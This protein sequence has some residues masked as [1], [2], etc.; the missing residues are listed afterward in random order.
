MWKLQAV[1]PIWAQITGE[2]GFFGTKSF[3]LHWGKCNNSIHGHFFS[4][5]GFE[6]LHRVSCPYYGLCV[7]IFCDFVHSGPNYGRKG[8]FSNVRLSH[9]SNIFCGKV[10][11]IVC[12]MGTSFQAFVLKLCTGYVVHIMEYVWKFFAISSIWA[13]IMGKRGFSNVRLSHFSNIFCGKVNVIVCYMGTYFEAMVLKL[14]TGYLG[15]ITKYVW[16]FF[17]IS[18][19]RSRIMGKK[20]FSQMWHLVSEHKYRLSFWTQILT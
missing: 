2:K 12:Y 15:H 7:K 9:F 3:F 11:V 5:Y 19:V 20:G 1:S 6:T 10:N 4:R 18:P 16:K 8:V 13:Q 17:A 14:C